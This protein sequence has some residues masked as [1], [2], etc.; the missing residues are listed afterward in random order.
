MPRHFGGVCYVAF[1]M[2]ERECMCMERDR[3]SAKS[4]E[5]YR[6]EKIR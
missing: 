6:M 2:L 1:G 5:P 4:V 3:V